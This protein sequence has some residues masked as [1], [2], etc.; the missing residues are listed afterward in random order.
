MKNIFE[1]L[2]IKTEKILLRPMTKNDLEFFTNLRNKSLKFL[3]TGKRYTL[4]EAKIW[5]RKNRPAF[6]IIQ[7]EGKSVGYIRTSDWDHHNKNVYVGADI[8]PNEQGKGIGYFALK[9]FIDYLFKK[10]KM[11]K[12]SLEVLDFN[13]P[14]QA[15]YKKLGFKIEGT[16]KDH[17]KKG[18]NYVDSIIMA[19]RNSDR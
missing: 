11:N 1:K 3:H 16:R 8:L 19:L 12:V 7:K 14:A 5:F 10:E 2:E 15:L 4:E 18:K 6:F 9:L 13:K 17:V